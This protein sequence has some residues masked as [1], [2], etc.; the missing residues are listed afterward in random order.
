MAYLLIHANIHVNVPYAE[1]ECRYSL[2]C[3]HTFNFCQTE[4]VTHI[5]AQCIN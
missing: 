1:L 3:S 4:A 5:L 2:Q